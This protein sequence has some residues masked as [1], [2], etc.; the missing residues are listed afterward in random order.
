MD[1]NAQNSIQLEE[2]SPL[3]GEI[4]LKPKDVSLYIKQAYTRFAQGDIEGANKP[5]LVLH[6]EI[7]KER[8]Q[9][10]I[11]QSAFIPTVPKFTLHELIFVKRN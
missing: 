6:R 11:Q 3:S 4:P 7:L 8:S 9:I 1:S 2:I 10:S 5:T